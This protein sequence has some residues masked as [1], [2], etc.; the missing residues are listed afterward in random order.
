MVLT[1]ANEAAVGG[2][3]DEGRDGGAGIDVDEEDEG[4]GVGFLTGGMRGWR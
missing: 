3:E 1:T 2:G 4:G